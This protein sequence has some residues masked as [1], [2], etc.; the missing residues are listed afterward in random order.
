[1]DS[2]KNSLEYGNESLLDKGSK[3]NSQ[4]GVFHKKTN[5]EGTTK[6]SSGDLA[7]KSFGVPEASR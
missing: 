7:K 5:I 4:A 6:H 2:A 1:M 3:P